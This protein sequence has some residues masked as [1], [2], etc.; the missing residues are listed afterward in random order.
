MEG[1]GYPERVRGVG[2]SVAVTLT[3]QPGCMYDCGSILLDRY[4]RIKK[5]VIGRERDLTL[6]SQ[7]LQHQERALYSH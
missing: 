2:T 4:V 5:K 1:L 3:F 6:Y 7:G